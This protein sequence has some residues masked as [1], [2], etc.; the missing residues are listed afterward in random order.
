MPRVTIKIDDNNNSVIE[1][2]LERF[3]KFFE[4]GALEISADQLAAVKTYIEEIEAGTDTSSVE[5][6]INAL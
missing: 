2:S 6:A 4:V 5:T 3:G 1:N